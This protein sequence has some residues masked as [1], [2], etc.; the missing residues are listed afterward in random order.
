MNVEY[1]IDGPATK[2]ALVLSSSLGTTWEFWDEQLR[3]LEHD[4]LVVRYDHPGHGRSPT[5]AGPI[6]VEALADGVVELLDELGLESASFCGLSLGGMV[7]MALAAQAPERVDRLVL[8]CT[9]AYLGPPEDWFERA[10]LVRS[11]GMAAVVERVVARWFTERFRVEQPSTVA[12]YRDML[13]RTPPEGYALC[14]EA[15]AE[16]DFRT[17]LCAITAPT[18]VIVGADDVATPPENGSRIADSIRG[19]ELAILPHAAHL[20]NVQQPTLFN[21]KLLVHVMIPAARGEPV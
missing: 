21:Q 3:V 1:R 19:A 11:E 10:Q 4:F 6:T 15:I 20:A 12:R 2:P 16:W 7:G 9:A 14:C 18:L 8:S 5:P 17:G 13:E